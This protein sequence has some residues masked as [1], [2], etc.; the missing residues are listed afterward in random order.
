MKVIYVAGPFRAANQWEQEQNIRV[1]EAISLAIWRRGAVALCPHLNTR[2]FSGTLPDKVW[3]DGDL[4]LL[5]RCDAIFLCSGWQD[6]VGARA[7]ELRARRISM[8]AFT[9]LWEVSQWLLD[10]ENTSK[11]T[12]KR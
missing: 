12:P 10:S 11:R 8:R 3:L 4:E 2:F 7:E 5:E 1:A 6:S 9:T